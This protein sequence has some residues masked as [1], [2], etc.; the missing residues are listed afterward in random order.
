[1]INFSCFFIVLLIL[2]SCKE[3]ENRNEYQLKPNGTSY[4]NSIGMCF[5]KIPKQ[6]FSMGSSKEELW[7]VKNKFEKMTGNKL[8]E[9]IWG[10]F[11][12]ETPKHTATVTK[13]FY[14]SKTSKK[15]D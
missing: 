1:M 8:P 10:Y 15:L 14:I 2:I 7:K 4:T 5:V 13:N 3:S 9:T 12:A 11:Q 6:S